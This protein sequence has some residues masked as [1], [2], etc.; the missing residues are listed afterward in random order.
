[1]DGGSKSTQPEGGGGSTAH[2][3]EAKNSFI[4]HRP[5]TGSRKALRDAAGIAVIGFGC[6]AVEEG[7]PVC[8]FSQAQAAFRK[9]TSSIFV[10]R[11]LQPWVAAIDRLVDV[12]LLVHPDRSFRMKELFADAEPLRASPQKVCR[13]ELENM[14]YREYVRFD[15]LALV[16]AMMRT[17]AERVSL[18]PSGRYC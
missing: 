1:M 12:V 2:W 14:I 6:C 15:K 17:S 4:A 13:R 11:K 16:A 3:K 8:R 7:R 10:L 5:A 9:F 18:A